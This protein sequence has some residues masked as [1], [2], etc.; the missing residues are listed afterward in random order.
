MRIMEL[1]NHLL[2]ICLSLIIYFV[3]ALAASKIVKKTGGNIKEIKSRVSTNILLIGAVSNILILVFVLILLI[4]LNNRPINSLGI[5]FSS[6]DLFFSITIAFIISLSAV[7]FNYWL[8]NKKKF[9]LEIHLPFQ[10]IHEATGFV[11]GI[12]VLLIVAIQEEVLFRGYIILNLL[13]YG[14]PAV[15]IIS[16][17]IFAAIHIL[18]NRVSIYQFTG[19][20]LGGLI[21]SIVYLI[22]GSIWVPVII[23]FLTDINN[24][25]LFNITGKYSF[26]IIT[27]PITDKHRA[28]YKTINLL[29]T[30]V[31]LTLF[32]GTQIRII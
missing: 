15:I 5:N 30:L 19:W 28:I 18:T 2:N 22:T 27:P 8:R 13:K 20:I 3:I 32:Y 25:L 29:I 4:F 16:T 21:F 31:L 26:I 7:I 6:K 11:L 14:I 10:G 1:F 23:H 12:I 17:L 24:M 9:R